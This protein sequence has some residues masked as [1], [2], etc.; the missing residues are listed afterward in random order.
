MTYLYNHS[1][2][3]LVQKATME[4][5]HPILDEAGTTYYD[6]KVHKYEKHLRSLTRYP[7]EGTPEMDGKEY[8]VAFEVRSKIDPRKWIRLSNRHPDWEQWTP[9]NRRVVAIPIEN[10]SEERILCAAIWYKDDSKQH[11]G[12]PKNIHYGYVVCGR[13]HHNAIGA[14][15]SL[16]GKATGCDSEQGFI[17]SLDRFVDRYEALAI[18]RKAGQILDEK[19]VRGGQLYSEDLY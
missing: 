11:S 14:H 13:R 8:E 19:E 16:T 9:S 10:K 15:Y 12:T 6:E 2:K 1:S 7:Y 17:T 3:Q 5:P 4:K 18:A